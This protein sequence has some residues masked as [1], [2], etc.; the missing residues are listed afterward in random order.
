MGGLTAYRVFRGGQPA[1]ASCQ[2]E[3][4]EQGG[5]M[6]CQGLRAACIALAHVLVQQSLR[7]GGCSLRS[8]DDHLLTCSF[9]L[10]E[11][12]SRL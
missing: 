6:L 11:A 1:A 4:A 9:V 8:C 2:V 10:D 5:S 12:D 3:G 7:E